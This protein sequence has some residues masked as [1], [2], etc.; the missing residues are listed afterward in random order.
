MTVCDHL[1]WQR[2]LYRFG[3][4][5]RVGSIKVIRVGGA[6]REAL[7]T[8]AVG[9]SDREPTERRHRAEH[10]RFTAEVTTLTLSCSRS[11]DYKEQRSRPMCPLANRNWALM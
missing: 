3:P 9:G 7:H 2:C 1:V 6:S 5:Y 8:L 11:D 10:T 4:H